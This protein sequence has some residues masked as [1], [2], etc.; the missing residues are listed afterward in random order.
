[1]N[2]RFNS[3]T[4]S[5]VAQTVRLDNSDVELG[6]N[7]LNNEVLPIMK[8]GNGKSGFCVVEVN[9]GGSNSKSLGQLLALHSGVGE[10]SYSV[11][12]DNSLYATKALISVSMVG[13]LGQYVSI[14]WKGSDEY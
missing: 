10:G 8:H 5:S 4:V 13:S 6:G 11:Y 12:V 7:V 3:T 1:M 14:Q 9:D 2:I